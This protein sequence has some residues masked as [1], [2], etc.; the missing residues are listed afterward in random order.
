MQRDV[1]AVLDGS[2]GGVIGTA[3]MSASMMAGKRLGLLGEH[4][5]ELLAAAMLRASNLSSARGETRNALAV[6]GHFAFGV[7]AGALFAVLHR[8]LRLPIHPAVHGGLYATG[9]WG[10]SYLGWIPALGIMPSAERDRPGRPF[11]MV[12]AHWIFGGVLGSWVGRSEKHRSE[13][14]IRG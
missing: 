7:S 3:L 8:R 13:S 14:S 6:A 9:V 12:L 11:I 2:I 1:K 10:V 4:P 5:P